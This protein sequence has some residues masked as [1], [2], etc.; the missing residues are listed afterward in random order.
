MIKFKTHSKR[1][2]WEYLEM[3]YGPIGAHL[4]FQILTFYQR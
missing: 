2:Y 1:I 3:I 4:Q